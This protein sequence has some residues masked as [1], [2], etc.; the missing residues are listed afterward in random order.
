MRK[1]RKYQSHTRHLMDLH[2]ED[3]LSGVANLFDVAMVFAVALLVAMVTAL[4]A[5]ELLL[6]Q[7][8]VTILKNP[9]RED[10]EIINKK[11]DKI[12]HY[13]MSDQTGSGDGER[14]G[15]CYRLEN[16]EVIYI[17]EKGKHKPQD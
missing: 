1:R 12:D 16:G 10:M 15:I 4:R 17:P 8:E 6:A 5:P 3:P 2:E 9:G 7:D 13:K 11:G 14:L